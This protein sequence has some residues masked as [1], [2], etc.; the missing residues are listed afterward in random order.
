MVKEKRKQLIF[1]VEDDDNIRELVE[2]ALGSSGYKA[3]GFP[4]GKDF[5]AA[6]NEVVPDLI[7]LDIMLPKEDG[8][9][10][11]K[12]LRDSAAT[13]DIPVI[14]LTAKVGEYDRVKGFDYGAD[15]YVTKPFY[16][17]ELISRVKALLKRMPSG[18]SED[19][20]VYV[21]GDVTLDAAKRKVSV[22][23]GEVELTFKE[24]E[25][26]KYLMENDGIV[27]SRER[28]LSEI[29]GWDYMGETR[30]VDMHVMTLRHKLGAG[31]DIIKTVR[32]VGYKV[33][34]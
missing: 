31:A 18:E 33:A 1:I 10:I 7:L 17:T 28:L 2:Y 13:R 20:V 34:V 21:M 19:D 12:R 11:L 23:G 6:V 15:D 30:T 8:L 9:S 26:L 24:F 32:N 22:A 25:L 29:W 4:Q 3:T 16:V 27:L 5:F 14:M